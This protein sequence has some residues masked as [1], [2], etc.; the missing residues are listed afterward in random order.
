MN[1]H[2]SL[3]PKLR[4]G[5]PI[6][7]AIINGDQET[8][9]TFMYTIKKMDAGNIILKESIPITSQDTYKSMLVKLAELAKQAQFQYK[10][11][12]FFLLI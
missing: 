8:G 3:L 10:L 4:G 12:Y 6:H 5:A 1:V 2:A 7:W 11:V 9:I